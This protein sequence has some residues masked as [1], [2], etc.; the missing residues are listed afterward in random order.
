MQLQDPFLG[1]GCF[2]N[3]CSG[4]SKHVAAKEVRFPPHCSLPFCQQHVTVDSV[5]CYLH[6]TSP[7]VGMVVVDQELDDRDLGISLINIP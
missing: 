3:V 4:G 5:I 7:I 6:P 2:L 1:V